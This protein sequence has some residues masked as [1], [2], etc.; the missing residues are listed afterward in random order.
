MLIAGSICAN[1]LI[2]MSFIKTSTRSRSVLAF[3]IAVNLLLLGY[4]K[5]AGF[6][7]S[8]INSIL[9]TSLDPGNVVLPL[10]ISFFTF[11]QIAF[12]VDSYS[13]KIKELSPLS[14]TLFVT[15]FPQLIAGPIVHHSEMLPQF[16]NPDAASPKKNQFAVGLTIFFIGLFKKTV[17]A[18]GAAPMANTAFNTVAAGHTLSFTEAWS[19][20]LFYSMQLYFDFSG[21]AD[22]AIGAARLFGILLPLNFHSPYQAVNIIDF[23]RRWHITLSR[24]LRDYLYIP[25]GGNRLGSARRYINLMITMLLGGLW[26]G[27]GW[28]FVI[29]GGLHGFYLVVNHGFISVCKGYKFLA[30]IPAFPKRFFSKTITFLSVVLAWTFFR[31]S[32][33]KDAFSIVSSMLGFNTMELPASYQK[34]FGTILPTELILSVE[35]LMAETL[36]SL[37][38]QLSGGLSWSD[39]AACIQLFILLCIAFLM[40]NTAQLLSKYDPVYEAYPGDS[41]P[42][43]R[44]AVNWKPSLPWAI[45]IGFLAALSILSLNQVSEF[46]YFQF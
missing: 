35:N 33:E 39:A 40:P 13:G 22:M 29:W 43:A 30:A 24:F 46:L 9:G 4:Y 27:A 1:Y 15:Y 38:I 8:N 17:L 11:Q 10:A 28:N 6:L 26:H 18:D 16:E 7:S 14:Y 45:A 25:L 31:A 36:P 21:Y 2:G 5:Y 34:V 37:G 41:S 19:G 44:I 42:P 20:V 12:L 3:G 23:W 32:T